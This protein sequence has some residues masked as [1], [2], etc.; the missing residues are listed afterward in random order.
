MDRTPASVRA[1]IGFPGWTTTAMPSRATMIGV[2][3]A[4]SAAVSAREDIP[5]WAAPES[6]AWTP[7]VDP[8][9]CTWMGG[10]GWRAR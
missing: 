2:A 6:A 10:P 5:I 4:A 8:P 7:V 3:R 9:P 1:R